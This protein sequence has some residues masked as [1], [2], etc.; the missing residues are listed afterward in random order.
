[1]SVGIKKIDSIKNMAVFHDFEWKESV[2]DKA[3]QVVFLRT[4]NILYGRN[5]SGKTTLSRIL[6]AMETGEI[7]ENFENPLFNVVFGDGTQITEKDLMNH[8]KEIRVFNQDFIRENLR[9][10]SNPDD[11]IE[12]FAILGDLNNKIEREIEELENELGSNEEENQ[13]GLYVKRANTISIFEQAKEDYEKN[14]KELEKQLKNKATNRDIGIKYK[15]EQFGDQNYNIQKLK[16]DIK[17]ILQENYQ[18]LTDEQTEQHNN[19]ISEQTLDTILLFHAPSLNFLDLVDEAKSLVTKKIGESD[20]IDELVRDAAL[21]RWANEGL[22]LHKNKRDDC[23]FCGN[24]ITG[25]RWMALEK[26]FDEESEVFEQNI[27]TLIAKIE[28]VS[29]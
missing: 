24:N 18:P 6:R 13:T 7:S 5:Y 9:F 11:N 14:E 15:P 1:M 28:G 27:N 20:K 23:A 10:I 12:P 29:A 16:K 25:D 4:I 17:T 26:H 22:K 21:N 19:L 8:G 3:D 2:K